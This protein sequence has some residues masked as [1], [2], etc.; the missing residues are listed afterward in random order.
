MSTGDNSGAHYYNLS[1][2]NSGDEAVHPTGTP[3]W[4]IAHAVRSKWGAGNWS[5]IYGSPTGLLHVAADE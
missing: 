5:G 3:G 1:V 4:S 2:T